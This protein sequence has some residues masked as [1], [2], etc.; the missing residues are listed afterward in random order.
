MIDLSSVPTANGQKVQIMLE[1][2]EIAFAPHPAT[3]G[4]SA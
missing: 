4:D 3:K 1:E 2:S